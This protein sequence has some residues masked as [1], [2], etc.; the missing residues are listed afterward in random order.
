[1]IKAFNYVK[2]LEFAQIPD[3]EKII[4]YLSKMIGVT[5]KKSVATSKYNLSDENPTLG[6]SPYSSFGS[7]GSCSPSKKN[8]SSNP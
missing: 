2:S 1:M 7:M 8:H 5:K 6:V 4:N 3:Y